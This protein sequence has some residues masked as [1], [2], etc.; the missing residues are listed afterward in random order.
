MANCKKCGACDFSKLLTDEVL[1]VERG[2]FGGI[3]N[4]ELK[5]GNSALYQCNSCGRIFRYFSW[6]TGAPLPYWKEN[7]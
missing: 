4:V 5:P 1:D 3:K 2:F 6:T 7:V